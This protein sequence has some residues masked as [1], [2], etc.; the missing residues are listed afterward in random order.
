MQR[1]TPFSLEMSGPIAVLTIRLFLSFL[2]SSMN[3]LLG[4]LFSCITF[5]GGHTLI[6]GTL[7]VT[8]IFRF[9]SFQILA[10]SMPS[11]IFVIYSGHKAR[12][13]SKLESE[14]KKRQ[15]ERAQR[16]TGKFENMCENDVDS[17]QLVHLHQMSHSKQFYLIRLKRLYFSQQIQFGSS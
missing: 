11:I 16:T 5:F 9:W 7:C 17:S 10:C 3:Y 1:S 15:K 12:E 14:A 4:E 6:R 2:A 13:K 8:F